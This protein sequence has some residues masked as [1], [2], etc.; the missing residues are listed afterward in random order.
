M[1]S[2]FSKL[3]A[4]VLPLVVGCQPALQSRLP[5]CSGVGLASDAI[6]NGSSSDAFP[7][8]VAVLSGGQ[9]TCTATMLGPDI[10]LSA[11]H[12]F[13]GDYR[14][15][16]I[17]VGQVGAFRQMVRIARVDVHGGFRS[18]PT[19]GSLIPGNDLAV[20]HLA[21]RVE[22]PSYVSL[23][24]GNAST[25]VGMPATAVGYGE[26]G[27][28]FRDAVRRETQVQIAGV[29]GET[30]VQQFSNTRTGICHGDS[31]GP[32][33][34]ELDGAWL[35]VGVASFGDDSCTGLSYHQRL[36]VQAEWLTAHGVPTDGPAPE[37]C[38]ADGACDETCASDVDC[39]A[40][41]SADGVCAAGCSADPDCAPSCGTDGTCN[42]ACGTTDLDC[43]S[44]GMP[45]SC[46]PSCIEP[47]WY[48]GSCTYYDAAG[49]P[50]GVQA[51]LCSP[52]GCRC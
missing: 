29:T 9:P 48:T 10:A 47:D 8:T 2:R 27:S 50:C 41:C 1:K 22:L 12:C 32:L 35:Q 26:S 19:P 40:S 52:L 3:V 18:G 25:L 36:D 31:G 16:G 21:G 15:D 37:R 24:L 38:G 39:G 20:I 23:F 13:A 7:A 49:V 17:G 5:V 30:L 4:V 44:A 14:P 34:V 46:T 33:F 45:S 43:R 42:P 6:V 28:N 51:M 11:A